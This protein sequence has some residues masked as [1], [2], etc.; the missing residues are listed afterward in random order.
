MSRA[1]YSPSAPEERA[2]VLDAGFF[3]ASL[4]ANRSA[5]GFCLVSDFSGL[6]ICLHMV[7]AIP[8]GI[9]SAWLTMPWLGL[10]SDGTARK[11]VHFRE[12]HPPAFVT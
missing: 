6:A 9:E 3:C 10:K 11:G 5:E 12:Q 8:R 2:A 7:R 4:A 1:V